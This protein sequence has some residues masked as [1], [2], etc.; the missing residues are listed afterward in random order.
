MGLRINANVVALDARRKLSRSA[1][2]LNSS[3]ERLSS[4]LRLNRSDNAA[5]PAGAGRLRSRVRSLQLVQRNAQDGVSMMQTAEGS[6][7]ETSG[8]LQRMRELAVEAS[9]DSKSE[10][11]RNALDS[12]VRQLL[13]QIDDL[14]NETQFN[15]ISVLS[16]AQT[17]TL[18]AGAHGEHT[19]EFVL[20]GAKSEDLG[21]ENISVSS[22]SGALS[23][24]TTVDA[25][26]K[27]VSAMRGDLGGQ[28]SRLESV[29]G[30]LAILEENSAASES[31]IRDADFAKET[32]QFTRNQMLVSAGTS[33]LAQANVV[34]QT[35][36]SLL[37]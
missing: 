27:R 28:K 15:G 24:I 2:E 21:L 5:S 1:E 9:I 7:G 37:G 30:N 10:D 3:L 8:I 33:I 34:P 4:G 35:A 6:L 36:L 19:L 32:I 25:A 13:T 20:E 22:A 26:L 23:A 29:I 17:V 12:E 11:D 16:V 14:A 18:Q 31:A